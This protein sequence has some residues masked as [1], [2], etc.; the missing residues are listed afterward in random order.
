[1]AK[2]KKTPRARRVDLNA[3]A[4]LRIKD[5]QYE[6][7]ILNIGASGVLLSAP[8]LIAPKTRLQLALN[9]PEVREPLVVHGV[10]VRTGA[11]LG[12]AILGIQFFQPTEEFKAAF[13]KFLEWYEPKAAK[14]RGQVNKKAAASGPTPKRKKDPSI[15]G[16]P[17]TWRKE[18]TKRAG[19]GERKKMSMDDLNALV[20]VRDPM[21]EAGLERKR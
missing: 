2:K 21:K 3:G 5:A 20:G 12:K 17:L 14:K 1:V 15:A 6:C 16:G 9:L 11:R 4:V 7:R 13:K 19:P 8:K 18:T 10:V